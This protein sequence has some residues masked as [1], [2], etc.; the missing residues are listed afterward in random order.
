MKCTQ[1]KPQL[2]NTLNV[3]SEADGHDE[4]P[5]PTAPVSI[6]SYL[7]AHEGSPSSPAVMAEVN[8]D[9]QLLRVLPTSRLAVTDA[10]LHLKNPMS[11]VKPIAPVAVNNMVLHTEYYFWCVFQGRRVGIFW[12]T[13]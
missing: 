7:S 5:A 13:T 2:S 8:A 6:Y 11:E 4:V 3:F 12:A 1:D 9:E 10:R